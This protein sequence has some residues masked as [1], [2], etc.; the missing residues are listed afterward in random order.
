MRGEGKLAV[1]LSREKFV[2]LTY[3]IR[4]IM[5]P[6][7]AGAQILA[8]LRDRRESSSEDD[9]F[10]DKALRRRPVS[11]HQSSKQDLRMASMLRA[12]E[13]SEEGKKNV[14]PR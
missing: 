2:E 8:K 10:E 1:S 9:P 11:R 13:M 6:S 5:K 12:K 3:M 14:I 4:I 7:P